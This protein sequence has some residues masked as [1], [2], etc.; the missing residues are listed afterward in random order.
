MSSK[1]LKISWAIFYFPFQWRHN[2][3]NGVP[4]HQPHDCLPKRF[5][6]HRLKKT[7][8]LRV[9]G[10]CA[11]NSPVTGKFLAQMASNAEMFP[12]NDVIMHGQ[13]T[14]RRDDHRNVMRKMYIW[15]LW[16]QKQVLPSDIILWGVIT[17]PGFRY[18]FLI[19]MS[20]NQAVNPLRLNVITFG[21]M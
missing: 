11:G 2:G 12:F 17:Y 5:L 14:I 6:R 18:L 15:W 4:N 1:F 21:Q 9:T 20:L 19:P 10:L 7:S 8:K 3:R 16:R 13:V